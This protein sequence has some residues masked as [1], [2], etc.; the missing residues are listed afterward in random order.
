LLLSVRDRGGPGLRR[1]A[2]TTAP[3]IRRHSRELLIYVHEVD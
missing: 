1:D 2:M 3:H